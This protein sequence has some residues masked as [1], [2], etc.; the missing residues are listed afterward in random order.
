MKRSIILIVLVIS[1]INT[2]TYAQNNR[3]KMDDEARVAITTYIPR[4]VNFATS[5]QKKLKNIMNQMLTKNGIAGTKN[6]RFILTSNIEVVNENIL[7]STTTLYQYTLNVNFYIGDGIDGIL[8]TNISQEVTGV[9]ETKAAAYTSALGK[10][11][12]TSSNLQDFVSEGKARI[13]EYYNTQCD[14]IMKE[15][16][17]KADRKEFDSALQQLLAVPSVCKE[18]YEKAQDQTVE[19]YKR[20]IENECQMNIMQARAEIAANKWNEALKYLRFYTPEMPCYSDV[21][22]LITEIQN[23]R[24]ADALAKAQAAWANRDASEAAYWLS[25]V[26]ADSQCYADAQKLQKDIGG[27]LDEIDQREWNMKLQQQK[28]ETSI[29]KAEMQAIRDIGVAFGENQQPITYNI[30]TWW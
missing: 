7:N 19:I 27:K 16:L 15:A 25:E 9:G 26:S 5:T 28:D 2:L 4:D 1:A 3:S 30:R 23:H 6:N 13:I 17:A 14:F 11:K 18:C 24:C 12:V 20:K 22:T 21:A 8:F 10:I 29:R